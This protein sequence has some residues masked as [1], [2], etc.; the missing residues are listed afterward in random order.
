MITKEFLQSQREKI[1][2]K[3]AELEGDLKKAGK[4]EDLGSSSE[5]EVQEFEQFEEKAARAGDVTLELSQLKGA[6]K[7]IEE[8]T[9]GVCEKCKGS[10]EI[11]RLKA[12][13]GS[14][15]CASDK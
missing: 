8:G 5:D 11:A 4:F 7:R 14:R 1:A 2:K 12:F 10:I 6:L 13:P 9:Y 3:I 15:F